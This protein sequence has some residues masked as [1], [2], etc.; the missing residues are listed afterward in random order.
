VEQ[1]ARLSHNSSSFMC[2]DRSKPWERSTARTSFFFAARAAARRPDRA[3]GSELLESQLL[4]RAAVRKG[5][6]PQ[7]P[8]EHTRRADSTAFAT[9]CNVKM[10]LSFSDQRLAARTSACGAAPAPC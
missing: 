9:S 7:L 2:T 5:R 4:R 1:L 8:L 6:R 10:A 3:E